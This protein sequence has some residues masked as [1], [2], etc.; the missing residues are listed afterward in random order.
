MQ[1]RSFAWV[2]QI[3][4]ALT[5]SKI[6]AAEEEYRQTRTTIN[7]NVSFLLRELSAFG[8]GQHMSNKERLSHCCKINSLSLL[9]GMKTI[10]F[11]LNLNDLTNKVNMKLTAYRAVSGELARQLV[12]QFCRH[13]GWV[14]HVVRDPVSFAKFFDREIRLFFQHCVR[15]G[16]PSIFGKVSGYYSCVETNER[17]AEHLHGFLWLD[18]NVEM[19]TVLDDMQDDRAY[20]E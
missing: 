10:W 17:G 19:P 1:K 9:L 5:V 14:Q 16:G 18:A 4:Y 2:E 12:D 11:T 13:I 15:V 20:V 6:E 8:H 7:E 3:L